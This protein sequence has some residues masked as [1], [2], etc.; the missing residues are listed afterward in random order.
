MEWLDDCR[1]A[2]CIVA[3]SSIHWPSDLAFVEQLSRAFPH[4]KLFV[5][6][7]ALLEPQLAAQVKPYVSGIINDP[8]QFDF[9][10]LAMLEPRKFERSS[11]LPRHELFENTAYRWPFS[12]RRRHAVVVTQNGCPHQCSYCTEAVTQVTYRPAKNVIQELRYLRAHRYREF[13]FGD[14][15]FGYPRENA[16]QLLKSMISEKIGFGWST[17]LHPHQGDDA[18]LTLMRRAGCHTIVIGVD[19]ADEALL[20]KYQRKVPHSRLRQLVVTC[21]RLGVSVCGDIMLGFPEDTEKSCDRTIDFAI[22]LQLDFLSVNL[23]TPLMGSSIR[24]RYVAEGVIAAGATG[25]ETTGTHC[26]VATPA[27]TASQL[28]RIRQKAV[29]RFYFR[30]QYLVRRILS[31]RSWDE[32][33]LKATEAVGLISNFLGTRVPQGRLYDWTRRANFSRVR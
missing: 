15:S 29:R 3:V 1:P 22:E 11:N 12:K 9:Q 25:F 28:I 5:F 21:H 33:L 27:L 18:F 16:E 8:I 13:Y 31:V 6:G 2:I 19:S 26:A 14:A 23:A 20:R 10:S 24:N 17:Y 30:P 32:F 7:E 4:V